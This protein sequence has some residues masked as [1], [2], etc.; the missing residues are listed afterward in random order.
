[1]TILS[2]SA[3]ELITQIA[4]ETVG[5]DE[6]VVLMVA[7][8]SYSEIS[9]IIAGLQVL[10]VRFVGGVFPAVIVNNKIY[11]SGI[12]WKKYPIA[13]EPLFFGESRGIYFDPEKFSFPE[14]LLRGHKKY[15]ALSFVDGQSGEAGEYLSQIYNFFGDS[16]SYFGAGAGFSV[17][18][19]RKSIFSAN[20]FFAG[21]GFMLILDLEV[22]VALAH[23]FEPCSE[24]FLAT[25]VIK[26]EELQT[27]SWRPA[28]AV[29]REIVEADSGKS[30]TPENLNE[31]GLL[32][33]LGIY[34]ENAESIVREA[35]STNAAGSLML[36]GGIAEN[37]VIQVMRGCKEK[38]L[39]AAREVLLDFDLDPKL[40]FHDA[41]IVDCISRPDNLGEDFKLELDLLF[42]GVSKIT[43]QQNV[44]GVLSLCE[45]ASTS[46]DGFIDIYNKTLALACF[47]KRINHGQK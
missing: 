29:Y 25:R 33:P 39:E 12:I 15:S 28:F 44:V 7:E 13:C 38:M 40:P 3:T 16:C 41:L 23:G 47:Y 35:K 19:E 26:P 9:E 30:V 42:K 2:R 37:A 11:S 10:R 20:G 6:C 24:P 8:E 36:G 14:E 34:R 1:M 17:P 27:I 22:K 21:M 43:G 45:I 46:L 31:T 18:S 32:Y 4:D 5:H